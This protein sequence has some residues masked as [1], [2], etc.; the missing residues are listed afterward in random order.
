M[1]VAFGPRRGHAPLQ[2]LVAQWIEQRTSNPKVAGSN[3]AGRTQLTALIHDLST[4]SVEGAAVSSFHGTAATPA[5]V[6]AARSKC[7]PAVHSG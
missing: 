4:G 2:A 3:P 7:S 6:L 1:A 5:N